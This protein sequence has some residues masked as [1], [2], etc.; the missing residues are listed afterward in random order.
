VTIPWVGPGGPACAFFEHPAVPLRSKAAG[1]HVVN[2]L[3]LIFVP[4]GKYPLTSVIGG[5]PPA[6]SLPVIVISASVSAPQPR[7]FPVCA[8][9]G[10]DAILALS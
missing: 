9:P 5:G 6:Y 10:I 7:Q 3:V 1:A 2:P 8:K 4:L